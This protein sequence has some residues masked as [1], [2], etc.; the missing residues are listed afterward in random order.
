VHNAELPKPAAIEGSHAAIVSTETTNK[1]VTTYEVG[2]EV[3][4]L[5]TSISFEISW[6]IWSQ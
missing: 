2:L 5:L 4:I 1:V 6:R 3:L